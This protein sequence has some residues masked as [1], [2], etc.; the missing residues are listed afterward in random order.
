[1]E[2]NLNGLDEETL[3]RNIALLSYAEGCLEEVR[4]TLNNNSCVCEGCNKT[5]WESW[6]E[7]IN[8]DSVKGTL[9][10]IRKH[11]ELFQAW[12]KR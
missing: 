2:R 4:S 8:Y 1:M 9:Y 10:K 3:K 5:T 6:E 11:L 7:H 12:L